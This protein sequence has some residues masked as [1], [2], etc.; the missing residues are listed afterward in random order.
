MN[1]MKDKYYNESFSTTR[2]LVK[3][4]SQSI[5]KDNFFD[6]SLGTTSKSN[7]AIHGGLRTKNLFKQTTKDIPLVSIITV[8]Y[9]GDRYIEE[10]IKSVLAQIYKNIEYIIV[11]GG[12]TDSTLNIIRNYENKIDYWISEPDYGIYDAMNK[13]IKL[14][15][16]EVIKLINADD[17]L[18]ESS[19][20]QAMD[21][22]NSRVNSDSEFFISSY[23]DII[24]DKS[25]YIATWKEKGFTKYFKPF[26]HPSWFI[27]TKLYSK[28]GLYDLQYS[29]SSDYEY[30]LRLT[31]RN[32]EMVML[33]KPLASFR[34]D[35]ASSGFSGV[36]QVLEINKKYFSLT[37]SVYVFV[38]HLATKIYSRIKNISLIIVRKF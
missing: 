19:V 34:V 30:F 24:D 26:Y 18:A 23:L 2:M 7:V 21:V 25:N 36:F 27:P 8:V 15:N 32:V 14:C 28:Y 10:T 16:G 20:I 11:D 9:N 38:F 37:R 6:D 3:K 1:K 17:L 35:G 13:G 4:N 31:Q 12:S 22:Y 5:K 29:I 33:N